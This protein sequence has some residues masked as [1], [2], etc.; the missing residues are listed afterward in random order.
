MKPTKEQLKRSPWFHTVNPTELKDIEEWAEW[1]EAIL[2]NP[3]SVWEVEETGERFLIE[4]RQVVARL[5][6]LKIEVYPKEH[7]PPHFHVKSPKV[8]ASFRIDN[9]ELLHGTVPN[10][11]LRKIT[12]WHEHAKAQLIESW[13]STRPTSCVVGEYEAN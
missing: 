12:F 4:T 9:C 10:G 13:N 11:E 6:G 5:H 7:P 1:L 2:H 8:D 3:C